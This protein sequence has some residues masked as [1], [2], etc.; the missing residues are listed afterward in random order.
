[1][2]WASGSEGKLAGV[3]SSLAGLEPRFSCD[4][5]RTRSGKK[6]WC[7]RRESEVGERGLALALAAG[8]DTLAWDPLTGVG[9]GQAPPL[10]LTGYVPI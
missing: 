8:K 4:R 3:I 6:R 1:M 9:A 10:E 5:C 2:S 7:K